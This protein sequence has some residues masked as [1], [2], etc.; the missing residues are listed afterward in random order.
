MAEAI[1]LSAALR[2]QRVAVIIGDILGNGLVAML[3]SFTIESGLLRHIERKTVYSLIEDYQCSFRH[4]L[5]LLQ[6]HH[7][8]S[9]YLL[10]RRLDPLWCQQ[11]QSS[12]L[13]ILIS[14]L[15]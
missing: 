15:I 11:V 10:C 6:S 2:I 5:S 14:V 7:L 3:E 13:L 4:S 9:E 1:P 12:Q 8:S